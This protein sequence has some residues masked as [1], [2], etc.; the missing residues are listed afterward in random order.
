MRLGQ[1]NGIVRQWARKGTRPR[2]PKDQR[3]DSAYVFGAI[4][5]ARGT[6]AAGVM[7]WANTEAMQHHLDAI[8]RAV[9]RN[10]HAVLLLDRAGLETVDRI[11]LAG[12]FGSHIDPLYA[13]VL[14]LIPDCDLGAV[15]SAGNAAGTG[16]AI[17]LLNTSTRAEIEATVRDIEK[18]E[19]ATQPDFQQYFV[20]A[21]AI[22]HKVDPF[23]Q[24]FEHVE[25]PASSEDDGK[26]GGRDGRRRNRRKR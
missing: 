6:G 8:S 3:Y 9:A 10:G 17:A 20:D 4:C 11:R 15:G 24:L 5:P 25:K 21:M 16:A 18:I 12:A 1:K 2:Q 26:P 23:A 14:G 22:P 13:M 19:T 7:P